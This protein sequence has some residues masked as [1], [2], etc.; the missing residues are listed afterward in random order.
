LKKIK[1]K[2]IN[3]KYHH[4]KIQIIVLFKIKMKIYILVLKISLI[5]QIK[6]IKIKIIKIIMIKKNNQLNN[7]IEVYK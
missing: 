1:Y 6:R 2:K 7:Q 4:R 5:T 3:N